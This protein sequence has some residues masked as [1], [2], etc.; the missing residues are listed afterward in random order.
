[1]RAACCFLLPLVLGFTQTGVRAEVIV[2]A[3]TWYLNAQGVRLTVTLKPGAEDG[4][5]EGTLVDERALG[6]TEELDGVTWD[7]ASSVLQF[8][9]KGSAGSQWYRG[10]VVEG[11]FVGRFTPDQAAP[12]RP[13]LSTYTRHVTGWN[14]EVLEAERPARTYELLVNQVYRGRLRLDDA[15]PD[16]EACS[17][18]LKIYATVKGGARDEEAEHDLEVT[19]WDG[20]NIRFIRRGDQW[21]QVY[22]GIAS[23]RT[24]KG[25]FT[26]TGKPGD[27]PWEGTRAEVLGYGFRP[28]APSERAGWQER[29]RRRLFHLMMAGNPAPFTQR[30][31]ELTGPDGSTDRPPFAS[32]KTLPHRDDDPAAWPQAYRLRELKFEHT[33]PNPYGDGPLTRNS[34]GFLAVPAGAPP[35]GK[36]PAALV[37]NGHGGSAWQQMDP[38]SDPFWFGDAFA[39]RG[40]VVLAVDISHRPVADRRGLYGGYHDGDDPEHDN[41]AHPAIKAPGFDSDWEED[42]ERVWD[43]MR[44]LDYLLSLPNVDPSR[45]LVTGLSM[46]GEVTSFT[47]ALDARLALSI[48]SGYSPDMGVMTYYNNHEC[49]RWLNA[50]IREYVDISDASALTAPRPLIIQTGKADRIFSPFPAPFAAD[51]QIARRVR[52]AYG[53]EAHRFLHYLHYDQHHYH[54]GDRNPAGS[55]ERGVRIPALIEPSSPWSTTWQTDDQTG[56]ESSTLFGFA[57]FFLRLSAGTD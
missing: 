40:Y 55:T 57:A 53:G 29:T 51:K 38:D 27:Y 32:K 2:P 46:G 7:A 8:R 36:Y 47:A 11:I 10:G 42:G 54:V 15:C 33:L 41:H 1:M 35:R 3:G 22:T 26:H 23:G 17:G 5:I 16:G 6:T 50:D 13:P 18:R 4:R 21:T 34:H 39:R 20:T 49:W 25:T 19:R 28:K 44:G 31:V 45:V 30:V 52:A 37:V 48:P 43:A 24:I 12:D 9:R 14:A 56:E